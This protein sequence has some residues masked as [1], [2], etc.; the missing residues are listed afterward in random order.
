MS[1]LGNDE[2]QLSD[3]SEFLSPSVR[4][5]VQGSHLV[6]GR[7]AE[8]FVSDL[9]GKK[10]LTAGWNCLHRLITALLYLARLQATDEIKKIQ[11]GKHFD[12]K[13]FPHN[14]EGRYANGEPCC[15]CQRHLTAFTFTWSHQKPEQ[16]HRTSPPPIKGSFC[17]HL[18]AAGS[19][20]H[21]SQL[22]GPPSWKC[23]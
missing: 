21:S 10:L 1:N 2:T 4:G 22:L 9:T 17:Y 11:A 23:I 8:I 15:A 13:P 7:P 16:G 14:K 6:V 19:E 20:Q 3:E 12:P 5:S 18:S